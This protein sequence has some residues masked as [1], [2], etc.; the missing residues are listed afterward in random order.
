MAQRLESLR[1]QDIVV[2]GLPHGGMPVAF[3]VAKALR[4]PLD[5]LVVRST[6]VEIGIYSSCDRVSN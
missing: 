5:V 2:L 6:R 4:A 3:E 1:G